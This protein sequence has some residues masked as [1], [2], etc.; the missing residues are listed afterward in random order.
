MMRRPW[1]RLFFVL[2]LLVFLLFLFLPFAVM[3][4]TA[5]NSTS[6]PQAFP[7]EGFTVKWFATL[8]QDAEL[9]EGLRNSFEIAIAVTVLSVVLGLAGAM[10]L[11]QSGRRFRQAVGA[12]LVAPVLT[13]G[14]IIGISTVVFWRGLTRH[15]GMDAFYNGTFMTVLAQAS[16]I[17]AYCMLVFNARFE[18]FDSSLE[19]A[20]RD[21]GANQ[22]Q[23]F[24][25]VILPYLRPAVWTGAG[26]AFLSSL[27][28]YNATTFSIL[29]DKTFITVLASRVRLG[30]TPAISALAVLAMLVSLVV[31]VVY[32]WRHRRLQLTKEL[33]S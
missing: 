5:F 30:L 28:N 19:E 1:T 7:F 32:E 29:A 26:L 14:V 16:F 10:L 22:L 9:I 23:V 21:L 27:E 25:Q 13:P 17:S 3:G 8:A 6:Y 4:V 15:T 2:Y 12:F 18:N 11:R 31:I 24:L 20:A 33:C